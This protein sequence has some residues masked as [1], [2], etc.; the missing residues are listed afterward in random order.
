[1]KKEFSLIRILQRSWSVYRDHFISFMAVSFL[2]HGM[3]LLIFLPWK[4]PTHLWS[5]YALTLFYKIFYFLGAAILIYSV[6]QW[7]SK[8]VPS[9]GEAFLSIKN[10]LWKYIVVSFLFYFMVGA[11]YFLFLIPGIFLSVV[12]VFVDVFVLLENTSVSKSFG[13]SWQLVRGYFWRLFVLYIMMITLAMLPGLLT[14][15]DIGFKEK[16]LLQNILM[17]LIF[18]FVQAV[19]VQTFFSLKACKGEKLVTDTYPS[20]PRR[21]LIEVILFTLLIICVYAGLG[22]YWQ[23]FSKCPGGRCPLSMA[24]KIISY[25]FYEKKPQ[26]ISLSPDPQ[27]IEEEP[28]VIYVPSQID[29]NKKYPLVIALSPNADAQKLIH[30]LEKAAEE[31]QWIVYASK[32]FRNGV[33]MDKQLREICSIL[34]WVLTNLPVDESKIIAAGFSGGGMGAHAFSYHFP[35]TV[36]GVIVNTGM[37]HKTYRDENSREFYPEKKM[38]VFLASPTDFRYEDMKHDRRFLQELGW[39]TAWIEFAGGHR[40]APPDMWDHALQWL[41]GSWETPGGHGTEGQDHIQG[42]LEIPLPSSEV[43]SSK[44]DGLIV[45]RY[46]SGEVLEEVTY[47]GGARNGPYRAF[48]ESGQVWSEGEYRNNKKHGLF[49]VYNEDGSVQTA[50]TYRQG[51]YDGTYTEFRGT[52]YKDYEHVYKEGQIIFKKQYDKQGRLIQETPYFH[53]KKHGI[54]RIYDKDEQLQWEKTYE[55]GVLNGKTKYYDEGNVILEYEY[56]NGKVNIPWRTRIKWF[57]YSTKQGFKRKS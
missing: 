8:P 51:E 21:D 4:W 32:R 55:N 29:F 50:V 49:T 22:V 16:S 56:K 41:Q 9:L 25:D 11:G 37:M 7:P 12:F 3:K 14:W 18:P 35:D 36:S 57:F 48:Y 15:A 31:N 20:H 2:A 54:E 39:E 44:K 1:M 5:W 53:N 38:A 30:T 27:I 40:Y 6:S 34:D 46:D 10:R 24:P 42:E 52:G 45:N 17:I 33:A 43:Q 28:C 13:K 23:K 47:E 19:L 26:L